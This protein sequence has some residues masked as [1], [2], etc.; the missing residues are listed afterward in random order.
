MAEMYEDGYCEIYDLVMRNRDKDYAGEAE[1]VAGLVGERVPGASALLD[2]ACGTGLHLRHFAARFPG[3]GGVDGSEAMLAMA[4]ER[5]PEARL[6]VSDMRELELSVQ[7][8]AI[9]CL[10]AIPHLESADELAHTVRRF[11][12]HL[13]PGGVLVIEPWVSP[14]E[15][16]PGYVSRDLVEEGGRTV[17]RLSHSERD[18]ERADRMRM[19]VHYAVATAGEGI[20]WGEEETRMSLFTPDQYVEAFA[21][22]GLESEFVKGGPFTGGLWTAWRDR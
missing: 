6:W 22:A 9:I 2:V 10:F 15:F 11:A 5:V 13:R 7:F 8:D 17:V 12:G 3:A 14:E 1:H 21:S 20:R 4:R 16:T 18:A 19:E